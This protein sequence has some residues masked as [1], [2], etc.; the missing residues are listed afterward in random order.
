M[1]VVLDNLRSVY[2]VASIFRTADGAGCAKIICYGTTPT[3]FDPFGRPRSAFAKVALGAER[4]VAWEYHPQ[5]FRVLERL[6][7][8]GVQILALEQSA[9]A[10]SY[11][12]VHIT[13]KQW[14]RT[15]LVLGGEVRGISSAVK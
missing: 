1:I 7:K 6:R 5:T 3:P 4:N 11:R 9:E 14:T 13:Q 10:V 12:A 15:A 2:N 8:N